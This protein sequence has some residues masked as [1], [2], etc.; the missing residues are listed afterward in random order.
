M[1]KEAAYQ[2]EK[3]QIAKQFAE[4]LVLF[5]RLLCEYDGQFDEKG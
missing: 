5:T 2:P 4:Y 3:Q 1:I